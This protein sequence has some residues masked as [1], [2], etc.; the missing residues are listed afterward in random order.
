M[1]IGSEPVDI[2]IPT[3]DNLN[4]LLDCMWSIAIS[5]NEYPMRFIVI[6]NGRQSLEDVFPDW[7]SEMTTVIDPE[8]NL[9][10][11]GGLQEG[12]K[13]SRSRYVV[14]ANDD[15]Y[16]PRAS[17]RWLRNIIRIMECFPRIG[18]AGPS[19]NVVMGMQNIWTRVAVAECEVPFLIGFC[20]V[21]RREA[22]DKAG[23]VQHMEHGGDDIDLSIR[24]R[25]AGY[26]LVCRR[27]EFV[28]HHGF[29]TGERV[30]GKPDRP[31]GWNSRDMIDL[32]NAE[33][34]RKHGFLTWWETMCGQSTESRPESHDAEAEIVRKYCNGGPIVELGCGAAKT[35]PQAIGID[36]IPNGAMIP[37]L[38][39][40]SVADL[41][42]DVTERLPIEDEYAGTVIARHIIEHCLDPVETLAQWRRI[43]RPGG[44]LIIAAPDEYI[45]D[46]IPL[47]PQHCHAY[48]PESLASLMSLV[49]FGPIAAESG[50]NNHSFVAVF[51]RK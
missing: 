35:V 16:V 44:R 29:Q 8:E 21:L 47:N 51:E 14:F 23:G 12:L 13:L 37:Y 15:I 28:Y 24:L 20:M 9:G 40:P 31:G 25:R 46:T 33:L 32:T 1:R 17:A 22:L 39:K 5:R 41:Q 48:T 36:L 30:H 6:N 2:I 45:R 10:W 3:M 49:G 4:Q 27:D 19:S 50:F 11:I 18:A 34:I 43:I 42:A 7:L 26:M 38:E